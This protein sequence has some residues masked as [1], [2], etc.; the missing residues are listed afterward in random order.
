MESYQIKLLVADIN[1][2]KKIYSNPDLF[3]KNRGIVLHTFKKSLNNLTEC[4]LPTQ[5][6]L[7]SVFIIK[8]SNILEF[9]SYCHCNYSMFVTANKKTS[10]WIGKTN[11]INMEKKDPENIKF[12][13]D[14][15]ET[16]Y[17]PSNFQYLIL[18]FLQSGFRLY[19]KF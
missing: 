3:I 13:M 8:E 1:K 15:Y 14:G 18:Q 7:G 9:Y 4:D 6:L 10:L 19:V 5:T 2:Q 12:I 17:K 11:I 16:F